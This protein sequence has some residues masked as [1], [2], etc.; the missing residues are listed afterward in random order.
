M[1]RPVA[2]GITF[3]AGALIAF[4]ARRRAVAVLI[5]RA[6]DQGAPIV[7][8]AGALA[9]VWRDGARQARLAALL[10]ARN[11]RVEDFTALRA[12]A[13]GEL[14]GRRG[15]SDVV[16]ASVVLAARGHGGLVVTSDPDDLL[17][18]DPSL[19]IVQV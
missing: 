11:V 14:C 8:P 3:D 2:R 19:T 18:L 5:Q 13:A 9:Q 1:G 12:R 4:E 15:T 10:S 17:Q 16:D 7:V 6:K